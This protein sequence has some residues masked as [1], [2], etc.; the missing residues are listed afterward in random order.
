MRPFS[1][2]G[3]TWRP[4]SDEEAPQAVCVTRLESRPDGGRLKSAF[5]PCAIRF[6]QRFAFQT[7]NEKFN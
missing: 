5:G 7:P 3:H 1:S 6:F 2:K 4:T